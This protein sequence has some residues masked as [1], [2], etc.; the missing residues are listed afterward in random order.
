MGFDEI[1]EVAIEFTAL[2]QVKFVL[3]DKKFEQLSGILDRQI[4]V[5]PP[6]K[7]E[8]GGRAP[9]SLARGSIHL[10]VHVEVF[11]HGKEQIKRIEITTCLKVGLESECKQVI[12]ILN[13][14][15]L[16]TDRPNHL[17]VNHFLRLDNLVEECLRSLLV[18]RLCLQQVLL[19]RQQCFSLL[20]FGHAGMLSIKALLDAH[21]QL[22]VPLLH[23]L[24]E[25]VHKIYGSLAPILAEDGI[26]KGTIEHFL[27]HEPFI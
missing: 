7:A 25:H 24:V 12:V 23:S 19:L 4:F 20:A 1:H 13:L 5:L 3:R 9:D 14:G 2:V 17:R 8:K 16:I 26:E 11:G 22:Q 27:P 18:Y 10:S 15:D 6:D 21:N